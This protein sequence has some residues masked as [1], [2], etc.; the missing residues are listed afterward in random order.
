MPVAPPSPDDVRIFA[1]AR[2][3]RRWLERNHDTAP[4]LWV[5]Y[6]K[7]GVAKRAM[8]YPQSVEEALC[9]GWI[10][11]IT[12][13]IDEEVY[14]IRFTPRRRT[15]NWSAVN[16]AKVAELKA[17]GR[18]Q[19]AGLRTFEQR[20]RRRDAIYSYERAPLELA[21]DMMALLKGDATAWAQWQSEQPSF[22]RQAAFWVMS[23]KRPDT[24]QRRFVM[25]L[26]ASQA[27]RRPKPF[28]VERSDR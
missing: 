8:T 16:I 10:D 19:S 13:R 15:S 28:I 6:F 5:G 21:P 24:Q 22:R 25:L 26:E 12:R 1:T 2:E 4:E 14:A 9:F 7:K 20:D 11:G 18:M 27:G 17:A 3:F 23:A